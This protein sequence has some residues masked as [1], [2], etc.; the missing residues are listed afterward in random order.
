MVITVPAMAAFAIAMVMHVATSLLH[1]RED[2]RACAAR[3]ARDTGVKVIQA[4]QTGD[5][6][7]AMKALNVLRE[8]P[9]VGVAE[10]FLADG[11][12]LATYRRAPDG[13]H[14]AQLE[15]APAPY[16]EQHDGYLERYLQTGERHIIGIPPDRRRTPEGWRDLSDRAFCRRKSVPV[17]AASSLAS[18]VI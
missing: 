15:P 8:E 16:H 17:R 18:F 5:D 10:V 12:K 13:A 1:L 11:R 3:I 4:L 7:A 6:A 2:M 9:L 14:E